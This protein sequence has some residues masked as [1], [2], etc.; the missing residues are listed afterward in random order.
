MWWADGT[1]FQPVFRNNNKLKNENIKL[2]EQLE[3]LSKVSKEKI[4]KEKC[5]E[6]NMKVINKKEKAEEKF[7]EKQHTDGVWYGC[8]C[9]K[10]SVRDLLS[11][12]D[13]P[14]ALEL[15][16]QFEKRDAVLAEQERYV[17]Y[18]NK[19]E[20]RELCRQQI[21]QCAINNKST[22]SWHYNWYVGSHLSTI[23]TI[24]CCKFAFAKFYGLSPTSVDRLID[25]MKRGDQH[26]SIIDNRSINDKRYQDMEA[27]MRAEAEMYGFTFTNEMKAKAF[28]QNT[29][30]A[31]DCHAWLKS[32]IKLDG[33]PQ[34]N[35][36]DEIHLDEAASYK[37]IHAEYMAVKL[38]EMGDRLSHCNMKR[39]G[40]YGKIALN[41]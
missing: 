39:L 30:A 25:E 17:K 16:K 33:D 24:P 31:K 8:K 20:R 41:T 38:E 26:Y 32:Y 15:T 5:I 23:G 2:M 12:R 6:R 34:P 40:F 7:K 4:K 11:K 29:P 22:R 21:R 14:Y 3:S 27:D 13:D 35:R 18:A 9:V 37:Q 36:D 10:C 19:R 28:I 1:N